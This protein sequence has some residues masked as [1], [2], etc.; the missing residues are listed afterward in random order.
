MPMRKIIF[1]L[2]LSLF[3]ST[4]HLVAAQLKEN[5]STDEITVR[6]L[7][8]KAEILAQYL[9]THNSPLQYHAQD[10]VDASR[11]YHLDWRLVVAISGVESTFGKFIPGGY[12]GWGWGVYGN[13]A[14]YFSSWKEGIFT[15]SKG[16]R[17]DYLNKGLTDPYA[18]NRVYAVSPNWGYKVTY[19]M[20]DLDKFAQEYQSQIG[21][22]D[23][24]STTHTA[25]NS[26]QL[27]F[28]P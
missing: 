27:A 20:N 1:L 7:D 3:L 26:A 22:V 17:E 16:L 18:M 8:K 21:N 14:I 5:P 12:N 13:Q 11:I 2:I 24:D 10:F 23:V 4:K 6:Q 28:Q 9:A 19:F 15:V 25:A